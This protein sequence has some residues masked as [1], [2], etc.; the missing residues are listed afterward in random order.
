MSETSVAT[1]NHNILT[2]KDIQTRMLQRLM[3]DNYLTNKLK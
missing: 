1:V 3:D 2:S